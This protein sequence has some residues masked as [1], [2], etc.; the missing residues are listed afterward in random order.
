M[1]EQI[2]VAEKASLLAR[3]DKRHLGS[4]VRIAFVKHDHL[5]LSVERQFQ[6]ACPSQLC[7]NMHA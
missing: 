3:P 2:L 6:A 1:L 4:R 5:Q 7:F